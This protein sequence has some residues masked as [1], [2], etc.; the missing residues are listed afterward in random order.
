VVESFR[1]FAIAS[2]LVFAV[3]LVGFAVGLSNFGA[4][5]GIGLAGVTSALRLRIAGVFGFF[6]TTMPLAGLLIGARLASLLGS[7]GHPIGGLFLVAVGVYT[8]WQT[9]RAPT[10]GEALWA[11]LSLR[12]LVVAGF[13][14]GI[15]N[16]VAGFGLGASSVP[17][18]LAAFI[19][20]AISVF[21]SL[22]GLELG[23]RLGRFA[24]R[25]SEALGGLVFVA[26]GVAL[27]TG[28]V[29]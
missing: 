1:R 3:V 4:S 25:W 11:N 27:V 24:E 29:A 14:L 20:G 9:S 8:L 18:A 17:V 13:V 21:L 19:I 2:P 23:H 6:E 22:V 26:I 7:M 10:R 28:L 12:Q 16:L 5:V 15:D